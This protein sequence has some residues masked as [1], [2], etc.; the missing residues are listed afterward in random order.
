MLG[1]DGSAGGA[2]QQQH[3]LQGCLGSVVGVRAMRRHVVAKLL[4]SA[5]L[6]NPSMA[7]LNSWTPQLPLPH[8]CRYV[9][10]RLPSLTQAG[11]FLEI[12][13]LQAALTMQPKGNSSSSGSGSDGGSSSVNGGIVAAIVIGSLAAVALLLLVV[14]YLR[15]RQR[16]LEQQRLQREVVA[17]EAAAAAKE[18]HDP[19][20]SPPAAAG[21]HAGWEMKHYGG[22]DEEEGG[23]AAMAANGA[24]PGGDG[25]EGVDGAEAAAAAGTA[26]AAAA[27]AV[28]ERESELELIKRFLKTVRRALVPGVWLALVGGNHAMLSQQ[29]VHCGRHTPRTRLPLP[30]SR[31]LPPS[32]VPCSHPLLPPSMLHCFICRSCA[33]AARWPA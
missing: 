16:W 26:A 18:G 15:W 20:D 2:Q 10:A 29:V 17:A 23:E 13:E 12:C 11:D 22:G 33:G 8:A 3:R 27:G 5:D 9:L 14:S 6:L 28:G 31:H 19:E 32:S 24:A 25:M 4:G 21:N 30:P 7:C 1:W